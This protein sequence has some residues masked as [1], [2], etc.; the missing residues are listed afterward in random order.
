VG[1]SGTWTTRHPLRFV[2]LGDY[3]LP[4]EV[5][6]ELEGD[7]G[8]P[9]LAVRFQVV[10]GRP[11]CVEVR[12]EAKA[13]GRAVR[14]SD[15]HS[16]PLD[17]MTVSVF[18]QAAL[19]SRYDPE[20]NVTTSEPIADEREF[21][22]AVNAADA[23]VKAPRRGTTRAELEQVA[24][25]YRQYVEGRPVETIRTLMGYGSERT[26]AR[27]VEQARAAGLLPETTPGKRKA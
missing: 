6:C 4:E 9:D 15:L 17:A 24:D 5:T 10:E 18:A 19:R 11:Q 8:D 25:L 22:S 14:T 1:W 3:A 7:K 16:L 13:G 23:A 20:T 2:R 27:R 12:A 21:W 26:A